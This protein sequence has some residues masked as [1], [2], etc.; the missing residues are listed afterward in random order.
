[1]F[2]PHPDDEAFG[3]GGSIMKWLQ[4]GQEVHVIIMTDGRAGYRKARQENSLEECEETKISEEEL[5]EIRLKEADASL[6]LLGVKK[7]NRHFLKYYDQ[8]LSD[9]IDDAVENLLETAREANRFVIPSN[10]NKHPDHQ[11]THEIAIKI[12]EKLNLFNLEFYIFALYN[13]L[14]AQGEHLVKVR[15]GDLRYR[16]YEALRLHK[17]QFYTKD[18]DWQSLAM[19]SRR[20]ERFGYYLLKD[21]GHFY[22]F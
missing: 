20:V 13:P 8:E 14:N 17:S 2:A 18:M 9:H 22:N 6:E 21:K 19:K 12:A 7:A 3:A 15:V 1:M 5:A 4:E 10:N 16:V 11:A